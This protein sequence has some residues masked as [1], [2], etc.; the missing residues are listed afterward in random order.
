MKTRYV[1][2]DDVSGY[3][4]ID[5]RAELG[6]EEAAEAFLFRIETRLSSFLQARMHQ[7]IDMRWPEFTDHQKAHYKLAL[8]EQAIYIWRHGDISVD[9][10]YDPERG[11]VADE[12]ALIERTVSREAKQ[13]LI[14][15]GIWSY[16][17]RQEGPLSDG[18]P[19]WLW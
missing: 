8:I 3:A 17:L 6:S 2:I 13:Q 9:S 5:L 11:A 10:G 12:S 19:G 14:L 15:A 18:F 1:T 16:K 7:N 4:G